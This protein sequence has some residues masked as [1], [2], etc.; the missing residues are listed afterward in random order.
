M[1][2]RTGAFFFGDFFIYSIGLSRYRIYRFFSGF[3][4]SSWETCKSFLFL[5][6]ANSDGAT[7]SQPTL[8]DSR[9]HRRTGLA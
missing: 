7:S 3:D 1:R 4:F 8:N 9:S 2:E 5:V 6:S